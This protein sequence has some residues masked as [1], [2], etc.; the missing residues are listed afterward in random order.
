MNK[1]EKKLRELA[2]DGAAARPLETVR[3]TAPVLTAA[4]VP[5]GVYI[6]AIDCDVQAICFGGALG[7]VADDA[8][9][10]TVAGE[11]PSV[12]ALL[13]DRIAQLAA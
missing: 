12:G 6:C 11:A 5:V 8:M 1:V 10:L 4:T 9:R 2:A 13:G 3:P 7:Y